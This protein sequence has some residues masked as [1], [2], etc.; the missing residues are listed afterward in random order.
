MARRISAKVATL[1]A[2]AR[3]APPAAAQRD[4]DGDCDED[5]D[6]DEEEE[7]DVAADLDLDLDL[8]PDELDIFGFDA[9][10]DEW[11]LSRADRGLEAL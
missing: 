10:E 11:L 5:S 2:V 4:T 7:Q 8:A 9:A 1:K 6:D 3:L